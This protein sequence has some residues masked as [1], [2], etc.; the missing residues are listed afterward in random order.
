MAPPGSLPLAA[1]RLGHMHYPPVAQIS[2]IPALTIPV[3][4]C[5]MTC[6]PPP[7]DHES[8]EGGVW[9]CLGHCCG[10]RTTQPWRTKRVPV[11]VC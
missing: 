8:P 5:P 1:P 9:G 6:P 7:L 2:P 10:A 4:H 11:S 3:C